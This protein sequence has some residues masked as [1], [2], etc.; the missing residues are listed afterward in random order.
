[1]ILKVNELPATRRADFD[2]FRSVTGAAAELG[3]WAGI[4][5]ASASAAVSEAKSASTPREMRTAEAA[6]LPRK[7]FG[8]AADLLKRSGDQDPKQPD[9]WDD[10]GRVYA[11]L[12]QH[13]DAVNAFR[14]Q[15]ELDPYHARANGDLAGELQ[16]LGKFDDAADAYRK[17]AAITPSDQL[18]HKNLGLLIAQLKKDED[19]K[20]EL[21]TAASI[22]PGRSPD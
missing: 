1:M 8:T 5:P 18:T 7:D 22:P 17:Q 12:N 21:E 10:L 2:S 9:L 14:K 19:G 15:I 11:G 13:D 20:T 6:A 16:I 4:A 3:L